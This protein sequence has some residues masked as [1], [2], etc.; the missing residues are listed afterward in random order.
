VS[1]SRRTAVAVRTLGVASAATALT[2]GLAGSAFACNIR[3]FNGTVSCNTS[4]GTATITVTDDDSSESTATLQLFNGTTQIGSAQT[5]VGNA[6][7]PAQ[8]VFTDVPWQSSG[9]WTVL[10]NVKKYITN[11]S[12]TIAASDAT[13]SAPTTP[14]P[15]APPT[16]PAPSASPSVSATNTSTGPSASASAAPSSAAPSSSVSAVST[17]SASPSPTGP[18]LAETGGGNDSGLMAAIAGA[19]VVAG[20]GVVF[21]LRRRGAAGR[22]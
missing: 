14:P 20:A 6:S 9:Q 13:C 7:P 12:I 10:I 11:E 18:A 22:H 15:V 17:T 3:D 19:L 1:I 21:A 4:N 16:T 5:V 8:A 2:L